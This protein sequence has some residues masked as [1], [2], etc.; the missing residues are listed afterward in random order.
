ME[1]S[2]RLYSEL[3]AL[4]GQ[5]GQWCDVRHLQTFAWMVV[6]RMQAESVKLTA[7]VPFVQG[8]ARYAQSTQRRFRRWLGNPRLEVA[9]RYGPLIARALREWGRQT[10][11]LALDTSLL[12]KQYCLVRLSVVYRGRA[13]P[14]AWEVIEHGSSRVTH[15]A[16]EALLEVVPPLLPAG[17]KVVFLADRGFADTD[18]LAHLRRLGWHFRIRI[19]ATFT[20]MR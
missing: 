12:W 17:V 20:V 19:K 10:L 9:P 1:K 18:L 7:W 5:P 2:P 3:V 16:Y 14:I 13:V 4:G 8:R 15:A 11:S 6:G